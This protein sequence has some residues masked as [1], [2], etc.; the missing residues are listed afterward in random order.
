MPRFATQDYSDE[1]KHCTMPPF[2]TEFGGYTGGR[3]L[4]GG[5][6]LRTVP[7]ETPQDFFICKTDMKTTY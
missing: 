3:I 4:N 6:D 1:Q 5:L 2:D 7:E